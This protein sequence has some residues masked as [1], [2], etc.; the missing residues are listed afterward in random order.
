[1]DPKKL[2]NFHK[3]FYNSRNLWSFNKLLSP[4]Q[5]SWKNRKVL[6]TE[7]IRQ[8]F[9]KFFS[10]HKIDKNWQVFSPKNLRKFYKFLSPAYIEKIFTGSCPSG[11][12]ERQNFSTSKL[13]LT[14]RHNLNGIKWFSCF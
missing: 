6:S 9:H 8:K 1:M 4:K 14:E 5:N 13:Y 3:F 11:K 12:I 7:Q 10:L 2:Q